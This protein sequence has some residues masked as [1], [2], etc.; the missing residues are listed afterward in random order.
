[1]TST[2]LRLAGPLLAWPAPARLRERPTATVPTYSA[3]TG[4]LA[5]AAGVR[6]HDPLPDWLED[7]DFA[8]RLDNAGS[9]LTDFHTINPRPAAAYDFLDTDKRLK[10][11]SDRDLA[12]STMRRADGTLHT[13]THVSNRGYMQDQTV[14]VAVNDPTG[15]IADSVKC[16]AFAIY[17][18]RKA[19]MLSWP[20]L[21]GTLNLPPIEAIAVVPTAVTAE[22]F[23][24]HSTS[25]PEG[26]H[27]SWTAVGTRGRVG[28]SYSDVRIHQFTITTPTTVGSWAAARKELS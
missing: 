9:R 5:A 15:Q 6:R 24:V 7:L 28:G 13:S 16:P 14:V 11:P 23:D 27:T 8:V 21:L 12:T 4:F 22:Y 26:E 18:G 20:V 2:V 1:M 25:R 17:G 10:R 19:C 3:V